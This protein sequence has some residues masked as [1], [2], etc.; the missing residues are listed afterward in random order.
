MRFPIIAG[1]ILFA[2]PA[3]AQTVPLPSDYLSDTERAPFR[4]C[5][6]AIIIEASAAESDKS[7][8][9]PAVTQAMREQVDFIM[10]E[11]IFNIPALSLEDG[12]KRLDFA[13]T[14]VIQFARTIGA[15][16]KELKDP[17]RRM[18]TL[19]ECQPLLW[20]IMKENLDVLMQW[21][22]RAMGIENAYP[23]VSG[24]AK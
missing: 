24:P 6:A 19:I 13:E 18:K 15:E 14:F 21:R 1:L 20:Q 7:A 3:L 17:D 2:G 11:T 9:P 16:M 8:L 5:R 22:R 23:V 10:S 12:E 4:V